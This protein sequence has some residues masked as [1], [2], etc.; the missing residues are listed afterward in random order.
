VSAGPLLRQQRRDLAG[1]H[2]KL[3][4]TSALWQAAR[5]MTDEED[6]FVITQQHYTHQ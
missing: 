5:P 3:T 6:L 4:S 1:Q 2:Y